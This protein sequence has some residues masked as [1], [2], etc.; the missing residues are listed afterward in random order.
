MKKWLLWSVAL[1]LILMPLQVQAAGAKEVRPIAV[2]GAMDMEVAYFLKQMGEYKTETFGSYNFYSGTIEGVPIVVSKTN[3]GMVNAAS[4]TTLLIEKYHPKAIINQ[5]TAGGHDPAL[6]QF[7]IVVGAKAINYSWIESPHR[8]AGAGIDTGSWKVMP[9][10]IEPDPELYKTAMSVADRYQHGKVVSGVIGT[11]DAW[12][13]EI[14]RINQLHNTLGTSAEEMETASVAEVAKTFKVPFLGIRVL[15]NSELY[16][17]DFAPVSSDYCSEFVIEV[18]KKIESGVTFSDKLQVYADGKEVVGLL[19]EY[20]SGKVMLPLRGV[21][22]SLCSK[23]TWDSAK[24][25]ITVVSGGKPI[26]VK[27][28]ETMVNQGTAWID[29]DVL[30]DKFQLETDFLG[31]GVYIYQ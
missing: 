21:M 16:G 28:G 23:V 9:K 25:Q 7:D 24:K 13:K 27:A 4:S 10:P 8:D 17:E 18:I 30:E 14:D 19:G 11:S 15:S 20:K 22:E 5:G 26:A 2:Q 3:I 31:S 29:M 12:N 6:H 1:L